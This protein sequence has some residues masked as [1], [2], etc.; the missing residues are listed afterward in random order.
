[1]T[2][3]LV[4]ERLP[5]GESST[6]REIEGFLQSCPTSFA[7]QTPQWRSVIT[8]IDRDEATW[9]GCRRDGK[10]VGVLPAYR[11]VGPLGAILCSSAQAGALGGAAVASAEAREPIF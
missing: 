2:S 7:Q 5:S 10:L 3:P 11:F 9:L 8:G 1:M 4:V 6:D